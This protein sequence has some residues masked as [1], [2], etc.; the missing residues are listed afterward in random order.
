MAKPSKAAR[1]RPYCL[2]ILKGKLKTNQAVVKQTYKVLKSSTQSFH[3][4]VCFDQLYKIPGEEDEVTGHNEGVQHKTCPIHFA[5]KSWKEIKWFGK[6]TKTFF[7]CFDPSL[8]FQDTH[9]VACFRAKTKLSHTFWNDSDPL[10][11]KKKKVFK[12]SALS[13]GRRFL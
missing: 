8:P 2:I 12:A 10:I 6:A 13:L 9:K 3:Q 7:I 1:R 11:I 5:V 4:I